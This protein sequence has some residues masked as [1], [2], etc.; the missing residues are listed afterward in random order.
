MYSTQETIGEK[1]TDIT[2]LGPVLQKPVNANLG[3]KFN[4]GFC[5]SSLRA[6]QLLI[7]RYRLKATKV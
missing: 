1:K 5:F 3:L 4:Q 6:F 2:D 7:F